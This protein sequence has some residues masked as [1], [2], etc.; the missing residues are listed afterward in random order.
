[1]GNIIHLPISARAYYTICQEPNGSWAVQ[2]VQPILA[3]GKTQRTVI[4]YHT[5]RAMA[6]THGREVAGV[7]RRPFKLAP[8]A[9]IA[10]EPDD[11]PPGGWAA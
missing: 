9:E 4:A 2:R 6:E 5:N 1:M 3:T 7:R 11:T 8:T 10:D